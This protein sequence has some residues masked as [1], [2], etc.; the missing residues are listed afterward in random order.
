MQSVFVSINEQIQLPSADEEV[1]LGVQ[2]GKVEVFPTPAYWAYQVKA[3][4]I[5]NSFARYKLG[6]SLIEETAACMLGGHGIPAAVG[7]A[8][9]KKLQSKHLF[10]GVY[11]E[12]DIYEVLSQPLEVNERLIKYRFARQKSKYLSKM[13]SFMHNNQPPLDS[14]KKLREWLLQIPGVGLKTA[15]WIAR[16]WLNANDVAIL[17]IHIIRAGNICGFLDKKMSVEKNYLEL[18]DQFLKFSNAIGVK[19]SDLDAVIWYEMMSSPK[20][21]ANIIGLPRKNIN[22]HNRKLLSHPNKR[23]THANQLTLFK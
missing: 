7:I 22:T 6:N 21:I 11:A 8:A 13:L 23:S 12:D 14:G 3:R 4:E 19:A 10:S 2:W 16:N 5:T 9:F 20:T 1:M 15:S 17:D 18:E